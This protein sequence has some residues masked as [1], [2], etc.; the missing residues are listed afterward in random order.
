MLRRRTVGI[1]ALIVFVVATI[2]W[3]ANTAMSTKSPA[4]SGMH[5]ASAAANDR[6]AYLS[7]QHTN[8]CTLAAHTVLGYR[9]DQRMQGSCCNPMDRDKYRAQIRALRQYAGIPEIPTDPY[10]IQAGQAKR[11]LGYDT[12][13]TFAGHD[14][15]TFDAAMK[16][17]DD[18]GPCCCQC[19]RWYMTEGLDKFLITRRHMPANEV[20]TITDLVNGC[21]GPPDRS[22]NQGTA[23]PK[24]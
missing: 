6:F 22:A 11:L 21:G 17:T 3:A 9:D 13:I 8:F 15:I 12:S 2:A 4:S 20:A 23:P 10:D 7:S 1:G 18:K 16:M 19:W 14:K 5:R 24:T